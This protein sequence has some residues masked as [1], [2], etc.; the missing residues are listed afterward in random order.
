ML[1]V[2]SLPRLPLR[3]PEAP[4]RP[5]R[6]LVRRAANA[7][8]PSPCARA[9][10][11]A[12]VSKSLWESSSIG[13]WVHRR[14]LLHNTV[15]LDYCAF[16]KITALIRSL[17]GV[18]SQPDGGVELQFNRNILENIVLYACERC[19]SENV[20]AVKL[21]KVL[22]YA[23]MISFAGDGCPIIG[24]TYRKRPF[25]PTCEQ[26]QRSLRDMEAKHELEIREEDYFGYRKKRFEPRRNADLSSLS[27]D[28]KLLLDDIIDFVCVQNSAKTI[29]ELSHNRA[30]E[31][32]EF[33]EIIPYE[34]VHLLFPTEVSE[35]AFEWAERERHSVE[36]A[37]SENPSLAY[38]VLGTLRSRLSS[39]ST[40]SG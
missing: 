7:N 13:N 33:G 14:E 25:G 26:L 34:S 39:A 37:Q 12:I 27:S 17:F 28:Q 32:V 8:H 3:C 21:H 40:G 20:G 19:G 5:I 22:Y 23:D 35:S 4:C 6:Q 15:S 9:F 2:V 30:W 36:D 11:A 18:C 1:L 16:G 31:I 24:A 38:Y 10:P 29:S